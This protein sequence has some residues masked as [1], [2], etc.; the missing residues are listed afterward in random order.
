MAIII[1]KPGHYRSPSKQKGATL[2]TALSFL[3]LMT[4]VSVS[5]TKISIL[6][7]LASGNDQQQSLL[8]QRSENSLIELT[9]VSKL[10]KP[11]VKV[12]GASFSESTGEYLF[13]SA[14]DSDFLIQQK[15]T[16]KKIRYECNG[17]NGKAISLGP[18]VPRC[19][20]YDFEA[21]MRKQNTGA[22][23]RHNRGAGKEKP[24]LLKN[25][26]LDK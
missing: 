16:D 13:P 11:M 21:R 22:S 9:T 26:Y 23:A 18:S 25:S 2:I 20:L 8:F 10:Y 5:A 4:I 14:N 24:N 3:A 19:D 17:F 7:I 6:D 15:I 1:T 12:D